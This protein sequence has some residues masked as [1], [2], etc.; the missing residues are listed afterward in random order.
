[1]AK[2]LRQLRIEKGETQTETAA[3]LEVT[4]T[5]I[6]MWEMGAT[7]PRPRH[8]PRIATHFGITNE[9]AREAIEETKRQKTAA[10]STAESSPTT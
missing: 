8:T 6:S 9:E 10:E 5:T 2:T 1:M 4:L 7:N 3:A